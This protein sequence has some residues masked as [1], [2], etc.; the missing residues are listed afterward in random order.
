MKVAITGG[1]G[2]V[3]RHL[4][5]S[6]VEE[7]H[8]V[9]LISRRKDPRVRSSAC[10]VDDET[11]LRSAFARCDAV[12]H[13]AGINRELGRQTYRNVHVR[14]TQAVVSAAKAAGVRKVVLLSFL[15]ARPGCGSGYHESKWWAEEIV[16]ASGLDYTVIK[17]GV[18]YGRGDHLLDHLS[19]ALHTFP[20]FGLVGLRDRRIAPVAIGDVVRVLKAAIA[21]GTLSRRTVGVI[22]PEILS[23]REAVRR[24]GQAVDREPVY[25][26]LPVWTHSVLARLFELSMRIPLI[27]VAQVRIL[28][29]EVVEP[30]P[31]CDPLPAALAPATRFTLDPIRRGLP[32]PGP[33]ALADLRCDKNARH[34]CHAGGR[35]A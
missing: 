35:K 24:V 31:A 13:C 20:V 17:S 6:L 4:A 21:T 28:S 5:A 12:A 22:G 14:G 15:R 27:S 10:A 9:V 26:R 2:F 34:F 29:E 16:R 11:A 25:L 18:I 30:A 7:D 32:P 3:G 23:F 33:F 19:R 8:E 1:T